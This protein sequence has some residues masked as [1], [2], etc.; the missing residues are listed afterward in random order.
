MS[1]SNKKPHHIYKDGILQ[2]D[3]ERM[4]DVVQDVSVWDQQRIIANRVAYLE[5]MQ[6]HF[7]AKVVS[8]HQP[9][10]SNNES[11]RTGESSVNGQ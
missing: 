9:S 7:A 4:K 10:E 1:E 11:V 2:V 3:P 5:W 8:S 6:Q